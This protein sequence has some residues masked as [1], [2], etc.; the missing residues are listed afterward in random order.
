MSHVIP[1]VIAIGLCAAAAFIVSRDLAPLILKPRTRPVRTARPGGP[2]PPAPGAGLR[3][4]VPIADTAAMHAMRVDLL[5]RNGVRLPDR[6]RDTAEPFPFR[7]PPYYAAYEA[8]KAEKG[9]T[10]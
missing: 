6:L 5:A 4:G 2:P 7:V 1:V 8:E 9:R 10:A 3:H